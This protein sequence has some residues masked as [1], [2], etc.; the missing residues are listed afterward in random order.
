MPI[1]YVC[2]PMCKISTAHTND[3]EWEDKQA[4]AVSEGVQ[5]AESQTH[6]VKF[7]SPGKPTW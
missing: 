5:G 2:I 3:G 4:G 6:L 7:V 1:A